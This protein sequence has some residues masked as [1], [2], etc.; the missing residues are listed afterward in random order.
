M[1]PSV[2]IRSRP[3]IQVPSEESNP[4]N[5][6]LLDAPESQP[7]VGKHYQTGNNIRDVVVLLAGGLT[8]GFA[9]AFPSTKMLQKLLFRLEP[10][11]GGTAA[12]AVCVLPF[13]QSSFSPGTSS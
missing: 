5:V 10:H 2:K 1:L 8:T 3:A 13:R 7:S 9:F 4:G 12:T 6:K 11:D